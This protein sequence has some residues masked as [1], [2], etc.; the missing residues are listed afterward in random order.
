MSDKNTGPIP[1]YGV[2]EALIIEDP[3]YDGD[4]YLSPANNVTQKLWRCIES[5]RSIYHI[6]E[7]S[8]H[9]GLQKKKRMLIQAAPPLISL[10]ESIIKLANYILN[11]PAREQI[12]LTEDKRKN[13]QF[14]LSSYRS[15]AV[16]AKRC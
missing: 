8:S 4:N 13:V 9:Y 7:G 5:I 12:M 3:T 14:I 10:G 6:F 16:E 2:E 15:Y 11:A 1:V